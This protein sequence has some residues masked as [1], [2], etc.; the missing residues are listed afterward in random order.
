MTEPAVLRQL[1]AATGGLW[2]EYSVPTHPLTVI[3][4]EAITVRRLPVDDMA[5]LQKSMSRAVWRPAPGRKRAFVVEHRGSLVGL[6][7]FASPVINLGPRDRYL[8]LPADASEKGRA[9]RG[10]MDLSVCVSAQ[11]I[12]WHWNLGKMLALLAPTLGDLMDYPEP[13]LGVT[14]TSLWGRGSQYNRIWKF[15][16]YTQGFGHEHVSDAEY[17]AMMRT[18]WQGGNAIPS[19]RFGAGSNPR[20]R[21]IQEYRRVSGDKAV[22]LFHGH[23][24][25]IYYHPAVEPSKR[26]E[27]LRAWYERWGRPRYDR[28]K[29]ETPP[30]RDGLGL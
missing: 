12:G 21:R 24:R 20:M 14:T 27:V 4:P 2:Q 5:R 25:G 26:Q 3:D 8:D 9:L 17:R 13:L 22:T 18:L 23:K 1:E 15:L 16:G 19:S 30:Y 11:P 7:F 28:T 6:L 29:D 10:Y